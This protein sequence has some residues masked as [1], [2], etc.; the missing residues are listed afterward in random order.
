MAKSKT[1][2]IGKESYINAQTGELIEMNVI[3]TEEKDVDTNFYK[4]FMKN[5]LYSL[6]IISNQKTK[7]AF[8]ILDNL[9]KDNQLVYSYRQIADR[10]GISYTTIANTVN[11]L[12]NADFLRQDGR[13][14]IVNPDII[15]KGTNAKRC[16]VL[17]RYKQAET[18][19]KIMDKR[20]RIAI[21]DKTMDAMQKQRNTLFR[22][23]QEDEGNNIVMLT[24][25]MTE[26]TTEETTDKEERGKA[27]S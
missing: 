25:E 15:F 12:K 18:G 17:H 1:K 21:I 19:N 9:N 26:K 23:V 4:L 5:F 22:E 7:V 11:V 2:I 16:N 24:E 13:V 14:L 3:E 10:T 27:C 20:T 6:D 8:W